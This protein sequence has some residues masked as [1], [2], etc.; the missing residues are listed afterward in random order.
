MTNL[1]IPQSQRVTGPFLITARVFRVS[2]SPERVSAVRS[3]L[4]VVKKDYI[5]G[6]V[7][8]VL[9]S[10]HNHNR[11]H[12]QDTGQTSLGK[13]SL[14]SPP[15]VNVPVPPNKAGPSHRPRGHHG[16]WP[17]TPIRHNTSNR[18]RWRIIVTEWRGIARWKWGLGR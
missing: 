12:N 17:I 10:I 13:T 4:I 2:I 14:P 16:P 1:H 5:Q 3:H 7:Y 15:R 6:P 8:T 9:Y 11:T 18:I